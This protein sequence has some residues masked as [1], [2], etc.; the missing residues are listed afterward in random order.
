MSEVF[1][2]YNITISEAE[3]DIISEMVEN[4][5]DKIEMEGAIVG[6]ILE[7]ILDQAKSEEN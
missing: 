7:Q 3:L 1:I 2:T 6:G 5:D 4:E